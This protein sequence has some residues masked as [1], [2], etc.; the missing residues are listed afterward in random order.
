MKIAPPV[1]GDTAGS[2]RLLRSG[3]TSGNSES[4]HTGGPAAT[5]KAS[6]PMA[7]RP[8]GLARPQRPIL[9]PSPAGGDPQIAI[10]SARLSAVGG[11][12]VWADERALGNWG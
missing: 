1:A 2:S 7:Q 11:S 4:R 12:R 6:G 8:S 10:N 3:N 9:G 5:A